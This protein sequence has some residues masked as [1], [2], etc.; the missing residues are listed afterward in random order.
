[1]CDAAWS[2]SE[3]GGR[4]DF[5]TT[6]GNASES[7]VLT[8]DSDKLAT[9]AGDLTVN[10]A[11][12][13]LE[14]SSADSPLMKLTNT[15]D[16]DQASR[17]VFEKLR[18]DDGVGTGQNLGE[19][20]FK[21]QDASQHVQYYG[22]IL[23]EIDVSTH[24]QESGK[25]TLG[26]AAHDGGTNAGLKLTGGS[27]DNEVDVEIGRGANSVTTVDGEMRI[28]P[29]GAIF[30]AGIP[31]IYGSVIK[32]IPSD[33]MANDDGGNQKFGVGYVET[34]G[35]GYG[36]RTANNLTELFAFVSIPEGMMATHVDIFDKNDLAVEV[37]EA[38]INATTM[39]SKGSGNANTT[40]D[41]TDVA[42]TA[43][44]FLAI[45]VTTTS[46]TNDKVY[47]GYVTIAIDE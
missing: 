46:A 30:R 45:Q 44:N 9:F 2:A 31:N 32:L 22:Y 12:F 4:L 7:K 43:T 33:F 19:I 11:S 24:G 34:D 27:V 16:D 37:F 42:S 41:I 21:G 36:M 5:Y 15:T 39:V 17:F 35:A 23:S 20:W 6:D 26:V 13:L 3:N 25:L 8:L 47:G 29:T 1:M 10:G 38:Q 14:S 28:A 18:D 40:I